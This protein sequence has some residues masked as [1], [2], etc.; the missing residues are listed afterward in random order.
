[1]YSHGETEC[2]MYGVDLEQE[3]ITEL[4]EIGIPDEIGKGGEQPLTGRTCISATEPHLSSKSEY[5]SRE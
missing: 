2:V 4:G 1:M 5:H 3:K